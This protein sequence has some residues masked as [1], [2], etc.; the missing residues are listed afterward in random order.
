VEKKE[1]RGVVGPAA[2]HHDDVI[3]QPE[4]IDDGVHQH[5]ERGRHEERKHHAPEVIAAGSALE[6]RGLGERGGNRLQRGEIEDHKNPASFQIAT[7]ITHP[8]AV[9]GSPSQFRPA[10]PKRPGELLEEARTAA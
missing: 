3:D 4:R 10:M 9:C 7:T 8:S 1:R 6:R 2:R 5:E